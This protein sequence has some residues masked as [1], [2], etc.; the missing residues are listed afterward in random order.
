MEIAGAL[1]T[2]TGKST[3]ILRIVPAGEKG[4]KGKKGWRL[5]DRP[6]AGRRRP[7]DQACLAEVDPTG[8]GTSSWRLLLAGSSSLWQ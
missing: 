3:K 2:A 8:S 7:S 6:M 1:L 5:A 4:G